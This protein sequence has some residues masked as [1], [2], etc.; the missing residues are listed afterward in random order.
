MPAQPIDVL[1]VEDNA[2]DARL[3][4][5]SLKDAGQYQFRVTHVSRLKAAIEALAVGATHIVAL[6]LSLP[7]SSGLETVGRLQT[8]APGIPIVVL[9]GLQDE[10]LALEA[11]RLGVQD[12]LVKGQCEEGLAARA[13]RYAVERRRAEE[14][15]RDREARLAAVVATAVDA[16]VTIDERG[17][18]ESANPATERL[19]GYGPDEMIGQNVSML[20]PEPYRGEHDSYVARYLS[21]GEARIIGIG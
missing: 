21:T 16:I 3:L 5:E 17:M 19:F 2:A 6:D 12:Y 4:I 18:I 13:L 8:A 9:T 1:L 15:L 7:D 10:A 20:M 11:V 14:A